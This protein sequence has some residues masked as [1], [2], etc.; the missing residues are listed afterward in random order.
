[1]EA[2]VGHKIFGRNKVLIYRIATALPLIDA[3]CNSKFGFI[4]L[5][6]A[7]LILGAAV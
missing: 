2:I 6:T 5:T 3:N 4:V 1:V 7:I